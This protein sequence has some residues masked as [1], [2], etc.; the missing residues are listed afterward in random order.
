M[1]KGCVFTNGAEEQAANQQPAVST[2]P[3]RVTRE[4]DIGSACQVQTGLCH[5]EQKK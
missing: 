4:P 5:Q 1:A 2:V 3:E